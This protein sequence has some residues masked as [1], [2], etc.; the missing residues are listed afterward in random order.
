MAMEMEERWIQRGDTVC[1]NYSNTCL[2]LRDELEGRVWVI[3]RFLTCVLGKVK[4][5]PFLNGKKI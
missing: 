2:V 1:M 4:M 5:A 3:L